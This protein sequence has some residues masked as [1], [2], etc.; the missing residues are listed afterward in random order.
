MTLCDIG[1]SYGFATT[2][3]LSRHWLK[4]LM[5][6]I[7]NLELTLVDPEEASDAR[8]VTAGM[9]QPHEIFVPIWNDRYRL[10]LPSGHP[11]SLKKRLTTRQAQST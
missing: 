3:I 1:F 6:H 10:A 8:I 7:E 5:A 9:R 11:L 2:A 4:R